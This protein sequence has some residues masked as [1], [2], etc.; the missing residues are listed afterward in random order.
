MFTFTL[1]LSTKIG[2]VSGKS[3]EMQSKEYQISAQKTLAEPDPLSRLQNRISVGRLCQPHPIPWRLPDFCQP[4]PIR[5][6]SN[7]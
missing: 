1:L 6:A 7:S 5:V 4:P 2:H 3:K